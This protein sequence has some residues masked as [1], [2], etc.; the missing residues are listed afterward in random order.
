MLCFEFPNKVRN[1]KWNLETTLKPT[2]AESAHWR[3]S[4]SWFEFETMF[5]TLND[6]L[7][8]KWNARCWTT[9]FPRLCFE[10]ETAFNKQ[11]LKTSETQVLNQLSF[12]VRFEFESALSTLNEPWTPSETQGAES[13]QFRGCVSSSKRRSKGVLYLKRLNEPWK[14]SGT[15]GAESAQFRSCF[16]FKTKFGFEFKTRFGTLSARSI[17]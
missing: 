12:E 9:T 10:F 15:Q 5:K 4:G 14:T 6:T 7:K 17:H 16:E 3:G 8:T 2:D 13:A 11:T 1:L